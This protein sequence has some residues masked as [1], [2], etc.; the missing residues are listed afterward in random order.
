[1]RRTG[2]RSGSRAT[3]AARAA[4]RPGAAGR[5]RERAGSLEPEARTPPSDVGEVEA[6]REHVLPDRSG[7]GGNGCA[8]PD[9]V[10]DVAVEDPHAGGLDDLH[11]RAPSRPSQDEAASSPWPDCPVRAASCGIGPVVL[12]PPLELG[13]VLGVARVRRVRAGRRPGPRSPSRTRR[14]PTPSGPRAPPPRRRRAGAAGRASARGARTAGR[15]T[16]TRTAPAGRRAA[17]ARRRCGAGRATEGE[18]DAAGGDGSTGAAGARGRTGR[19]GPP[20]PLGARGLRR[21][22][23]SRLGRP[24]HHWRR[25]RGRGRGGGVTGAGGAGVVAAVARAAWPRSAAAGPAGAA[26]E[27]GALPGAW[28]GRRSAGRRRLGP[29]ERRPRL[30]GGQLHDQGRPGRRGGLRPRS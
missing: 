26:Q 7:I 28:A 27:R 4:R 8:M 14:R 15:R 2:G 1:M 9:R 3:Q 23:R 19:R 5:E 13:E 18:R 16:G 10:L 11:R 6:D 17:R 22:R 20:A 21:R 12:D 24:G 25:G 30:G 29:D